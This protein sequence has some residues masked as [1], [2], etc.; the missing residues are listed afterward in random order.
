FETESDYEQDQLDRAGRFLTE[1]FAGMTLSETRE[2]ILAMMAE[3]KALYDRL[4]HDALTLGSA[5]VDDGTAAAGVVGS[6]R[7][8]LDRAS[9]LIDK[10]E[11]ADAERLNA[12]FRAFEE[13]H[14]ILRI[15]NRCIEEGQ[16]GVRVLIGSETDSP[17]LNQCTLITSTYGP[18]GAP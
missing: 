11:F 5:S 2:R 13:K 14:H 7:V 16:S 4:L 9:N 17:E 1:T 15:L 10:P 6:H 18:E 3:E 12:I 8:F